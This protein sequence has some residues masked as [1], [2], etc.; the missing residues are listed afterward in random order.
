MSWEL[1]LVI[2]AVIIGI[3]LV[4]RIIT[5]SFRHKDKDDEHLRDDTSPGHDSADDDS[6]GV[7]D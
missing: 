2:F 1:L 7:D 3:P 4:R 6:D 5:G